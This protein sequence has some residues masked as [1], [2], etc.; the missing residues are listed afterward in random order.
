MIT[1]YHLPQLARRMFGCGITLIVKAL[2]SANDIVFVKCIILY[3]VSE[4]VVCILQVVICRICNLLKSAVCFIIVMIQCPACFIRN[5]INFAG[6]SICYRS[7]KDTVY[8]SC[9]E[10]VAAVIGVCGWNQVDICL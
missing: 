2:I 10:P 6:D 4:A 1:I 8:G 7:C 5:N 3:S 9:K